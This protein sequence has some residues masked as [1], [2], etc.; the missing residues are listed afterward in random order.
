MKIVQ[1]LQQ[2][3]AVAKQIDVKLI[4]P[5]YPATFAFMLILLE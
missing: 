5:E 2:L 3:N 4:R 1:A